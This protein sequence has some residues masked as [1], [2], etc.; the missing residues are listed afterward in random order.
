MSSLAR[1]AMAEMLGTAFLVFFGCGAII[2]TSYADAQYKLFGIAV[3]HALALSIGISAT[4]GISGGHLN[5]AVTLGMLAIRRI[6]VPDAF[7]YIASQLVGALIAALAVREVLPDNV[8][9]VL[10]Y[11]TPVL[12]ATVSIG[13]GI[14]LEAIGTF[15]LMSA[16]MGTI[17]ASNAPRIAGFGVGL[18]LMPI[19]MVIGVLTGAAVNPARAFGPA[20]ISGQVTAQVVWWIGPILGAVAAALLWQ[21]V[22]LKQQPE[23][24]LVPTK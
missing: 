7:V 23:E 1:R 22:L 10:A 11:G 4:M 15:V 6:T 19:I 16:V 2:M 13:H 3:V 24:P 20:I 21:H 18:A 5:P 9:R 12:Y 17:V 8:G 14:V